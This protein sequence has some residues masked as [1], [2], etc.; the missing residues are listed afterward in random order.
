MGFLH[1]GQADLELPASG[2]PRGLAP[3]SA[4]IIGMNRHT[5]PPRR[6]PVDATLTD[7]FLLPT[8]QDIPSGGAPRVTSVTLSAG[9]AFL[10]APRLSG[11]WC[12]VNG[13]ESPLDDVWRSG[14]SE[15]SIQLI[16][17]G[18]EKPDRRPRAEKHHELQRCCFS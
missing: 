7:K 13:T 6:E 11:S 3:Q 2:D 9:A 1:V 16:E 10:S 14:K 12:G 15:Q 5:Q 8:D 17:K 18:A 4:G